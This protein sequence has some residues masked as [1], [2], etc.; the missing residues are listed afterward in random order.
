MPAGTKI[1]FS[2]TNGKVL[3]TTTSFNVPDSIGFGTT[4]NVLLQTDATLATG[5]CANTNDLG[6]LNI[7][8]TSPKGL[9][10]ENSYF[11]KDDPAASF[12]P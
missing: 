10:T 8:V 12:P 11:V 2:S 3:N 5:K 4:F 9:I 7:K 6:I 1:E